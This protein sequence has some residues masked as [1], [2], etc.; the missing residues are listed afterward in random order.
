MFCGNVFGTFAAL[1]HRLSFSPAERV[2]YQALKDR[3]KAGLCLLDVAVYNMHC[4]LLHSVTSWRHHR[5]LCA[6]L[7]FE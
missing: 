7:L 1:L 5:D 2:F 6:V 3:S 4:L